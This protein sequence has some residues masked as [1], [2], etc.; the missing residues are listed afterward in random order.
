VAEASDRHKEVTASEQAAAAAHAAEVEAAAARLA[1]AERAHAESQEELAD[2]HA[3][4]EA[5]SAASAA[6]SEASEEHKAAV[7][8]QRE[9]MEAEHRGRELSLETEVEAL[10]TEHSSALSELN[11]FKR[12]HLSAHDTLQRELEDVGAERAELQSI[13]DAEKRKLEQHE[14]AI[15]KNGEL[16]E[17]ITKL[18]TQLKDAEVLIAHHEKQLQVKKHWEESPT[19]TRDS[20]NWNWRSPVP[21][22][23]AARATAKR[24][25]A[26]QQSNSSPPDDDLNSNKELLR[27]QRRQRRR[28]VV[29]KIQQIW[30]SQHVS[31]ARLDSEGGIEGIGLQDTSD[32]EFKEAFKFFDCNGFISASELCE[33]LT[34]LEDRLTKEEVKPL[35]H[36][37]DANGDGLINFEEFVSGILR[38][39]PQTSS[40]PDELHKRLLPPAQAGSSVRTETVLARETSTCGGATS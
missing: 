28:K 26:S 23:A 29:K 19:G 21:S 39:T 25:T 30:R 11:T 17:E 16:K 10:K 5:A 13:L 27:Q 34:T 36:K 38:T 18:E 14:S 8:A 32:E 33:H 31:G 20:Y 1:A 2:K 40:S 7:L 6:R 24:A 22:S 15:Q 12:E 4:L 3:A 9:Q 37:A 35:I